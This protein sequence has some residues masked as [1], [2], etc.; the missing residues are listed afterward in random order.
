MRFGHSLAIAVCE[1]SLIYGVKLG[2]N[3]PSLMLRHN[4]GLKF[5]IGE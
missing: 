4:E 1:I 3:W 5:S 2:S